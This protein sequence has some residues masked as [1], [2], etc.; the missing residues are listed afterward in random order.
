ML[1]AQHIIDMLDG[2]AD[3]NSSVITSTMEDA[4]LHVTEVD[5]VQDTEVVFDLLH[6]YYTMHL[7]QL[8]GHIED[9]ASED[10]GDVGST[11]LKTAP[12]AGKTKWF[13]EYEK[14]LEGLSP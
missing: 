9:V 7:L 5:G 14:V 3:V 11:Y 2:I 4:R 10:V 13:L 12:E 8:W 6:K 1:I